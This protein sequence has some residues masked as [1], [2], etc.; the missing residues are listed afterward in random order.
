MQP[1]LLLRHHW[2]LLRLERRAQALQQ[3]WRA[4]PAPC[5]EP[6]C[7]PACNL[8]RQ[9][10]G[11]KQ[12]SCAA[13]DAD[14][15]AP[16]LSAT[17]PHALA[18]SLT[19]ARAAHTTSSSSPYTQ[20]RSPIGRSNG[21][22]QCLWGFVAVYIGACCARLLPVHTGWLSSDARGSL[23]LSLSVEACDKQSSWTVIL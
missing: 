5:P 20:T 9:G 2:P 18:T 1:L 3:T 6:P 11:I 17:C 22:K 19:R 16:R 21:T 4:A 10:S 13:M 23:S 12:C 14:S 8:P 7:L 15:V